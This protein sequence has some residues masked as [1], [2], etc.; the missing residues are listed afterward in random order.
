MVMSLGDSVS[1]SKEFTTMHVSIHEDNDQASILA[2]MLPSQ[3]IPQSKYHATKT[4][5]FCKE[6]VKRGIKLVK[7]ETVEELSDM[8]TKAWSR[9]TFGYLR[10]TLMGL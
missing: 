9:V 4:I 3:Y 10:S 7:V 1:L 2:E 6:I 8:L 5:W